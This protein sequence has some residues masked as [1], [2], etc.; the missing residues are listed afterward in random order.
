MWLRFYFFRVLFVKQGRVGLQHLVLPL[1][2]LSLPWGLCLPTR[3]RAL[4][5][6]SAPLLAGTRC[7]GRLQLLV[8]AELGS[9]RAR[10]GHSVQFQPH[11]HQESKVLPVL[12]VFLF[13][14]LP[15]KSPSC[16]FLLR[17]S[18]HWHLTVAW[19]CSRKSFP[20]GLLG[21]II[22]ICWSQ[23]PSRCRHCWVQAKHSGC[24][25]DYQAER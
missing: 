5:G 18:C 7:P 3:P 23:P 25:P 10:A 6:G 15:Q 16:L 24:F 12:P 14:Q 2:V 17:D 1:W 22:L 21:S 4:R 8:P 20:A 9:Q 13:K 19:C 11:I